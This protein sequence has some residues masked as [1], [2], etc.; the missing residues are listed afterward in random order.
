MHAH[1]HTQREE[2]ERRLTPLRGDEGGELAVG[3]EK[4]HRLRRVHPHARLRQVTSY[5]IYLS[6]YWF[7][8]HPPSITYI[9]AHI[10]ANS[11]EVACG[12]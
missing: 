9:G 11:Q 2:R 6:S 4:A 3:D 10:R 5:S 12:E 7:V 1:T 8:M